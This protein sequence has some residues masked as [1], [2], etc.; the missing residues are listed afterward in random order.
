MENFYYVLGVNTFTSPIDI[1][2]LLPKLTTN[3]E[4][5]IHSY[6]LTLEGSSANP[7]VEVMR[8]NCNA[9]EFDK[10]LKQHHLI[11]VLAIEVTACENISM[12]EIYC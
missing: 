5:S 7:D 3:W 11:E 2:H 4:C 10:S 6:C 9:I 1:T 8:R 12:E